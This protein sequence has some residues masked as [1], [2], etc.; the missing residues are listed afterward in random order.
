MPKQSDLATTTNTND[1]AGLKGAEVDGLEH[2]LDVDWPKEPSA[3]PKESDQAADM[4][5][6]DASEKPCADVDAFASSMDVDWPS[7]PNTSAGTICPKSAA[8]AEP[9]P[10]K[11]ENGLTCADV[12]GVENAPDVAL[13]KAQSAA[14]EDAALQ[15]SIA[16]CPGESDQPADMQI[17]DAVVTP[18]AGVDSVADALDVDLPKEIEKLPEVATPQVSAD[19][20]PQDGLKD[21]AD[22]EWPT[23]SNAT[24]EAAELQPSIAPSPG[25]SD[26]PA[27]LGTSEK[28]VEPSADVDALAN[29]LDIDW[30][31]EPNTSIQSMAQQPTVEAELKESDNM[32][33]PSTNEGGV[34]SS[35]ADGLEDALEVPCAKAPDAT[36]EVATPQP[37][38]TLTV[39]ECDQPADMQ[40]TDAGV[41]LCAAGVTLCADVDALVAAEATPKESD[42]VTTLSTDALEDTLGVDCP[43]EPSARAEDAAM[44]PSTT[45]SPGESDQPTDMETNDAVVK[46]C[47]DLDALASS[48][49]V[50]WP[51]EPNASSEATLQ[52]PAAEATP[53]DSDPV[54]ISSTIE[55]SLKSAEV[56]GLEDALDVNLQTEPNATAET[57]EM[58]PSMTQSPGEPDQSGELGTSD[59][60]VTP[61]AEVETAA[62]ALDVD[63]PKETVAAPH[64]SAD[65]ASKESDHVA[66]LSTEE[67]GLQA[68]EVDGLKDVLDADWP[69]DSKGTVEPAALQPSVTPSP[70]ESHPPADLGTSDSVM[71]PSADVNALADALD[72]DWP[73]EIQGLPEATVPQLSAMEAPKESD[74]LAI[75]STNEEGLQDTKVDGLGAEMQPSVT[76]SPGESDQS[77]ELGT[78]DKVMMPSPDVDAVADALDVNWPEET[79]N[80]PKV[81]APQSSADAAPTESDHVATLSTENDGLKDALDADRPTDSNATVEAAALQPS[82]TPGAEGSAE[83]AE[84]G[85]QDTVIEPSADVD[86]LADALDVG[87]PNE[88]KEL[89]EAPAPQPSAVVAPKES[90]PLATLSANGDWNVDWPGQPTTSVDATVSQ[91]SEEA[92][93]KE[94]AA[95]TNLS[96]STAGLKSAEVA[97]LEDALDVDW[98]TVPNTTAEAVV[99]QQP[100]AVATNESDT[101]AVLSTK[102]AGDAEVDGL[103]KALEI[104]RPSEPSATVEDVSTHPS[105]TRV[106]PEVVADA[107]GSEQP[108]EAAAAVVLPSTDVPEDAWDFDWANDAETAKAPPA[109]GSAVVDK[110]S[111][112]S[113]SPS[114]KDVPEDAWDFDWADAAD[115]P[116]LTAPAVEQPHLAVPT[117]VVAKNLGNSASIASV[118]SVVAPPSAGAHDPWDDLDID[119]SDPTAKPA[120]MQ[121]AVAS[122]AAQPVPSAVEDP[123]AEFS[124]GLTA[125]PLAS[126]Q[127]PARSSAVEEPKSSKLKLDDFDPFAEF[128]L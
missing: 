4:K 118:D 1:N 109:A 58:Q 83:P 120:A 104:D 10:S 28:V 44:Q 22:A 29:A 14:A 101:A 57:V 74:P 46:P 55:D 81:V 8:E 9:T 82:I 128:T 5:S 62:D 66:T 33:S 48:L 67:G 51:V 108:A 3:T 27:E 85:T 38:V 53:K 7:E 60:V 19:A 17:S 30:P 86:T 70:G 20:A 91:F 36:A 93:S 23:D 18:C 80:L 97:G 112:I 24:V 72:V 56:D 123:F 116:V 61:S 90:D 113:A 11:S 117:E 50:D 63:W 39:E 65:A 84:P 77:A 102:D 87:W 32:P 110:P 71:K 122:A 106:E 34:Q 25:E 98:P 15:A 105:D 114:P 95:M 103:H 42:L 47:A 43:K 40:T 16:P 75:L 31:S 35:E 59:A 94:L 99:L 107:S 21:A 69:T 54:I 49:D 92:A 111:E 88:T 13:P 68:A 73:G 100:A 41:T 126:S 125:S 45:P 78:N 26:Q 64:L 12:G 2:A 6:N 115:V 89:P 52:Q 37:S 124:M 76:Q 79:E 96:T 119:F 121:G 127:P